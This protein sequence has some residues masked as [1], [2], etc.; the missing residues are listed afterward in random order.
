MEKV[1][2]VDIWP[3][4]GHKSFYGKAKIIFDKEANVAY[5]RSYNTI[6][7]SF[8]LN[9]GVF[10]RVWNGYSATTMRHINAF[11]AYHGLLAL[12]KS[13]WLSLKPFM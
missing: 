4:D 10:R 1:Y 3:V 9:S 7:C 2:C 11:R 6:V 12:S 13:E 5:L 8:N